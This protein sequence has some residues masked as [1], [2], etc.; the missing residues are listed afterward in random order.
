MTPTALVLSRLPDAKR[1]GRGWVARCPAHDDRRPSLSVAEG[2][3][4]GALLHCHA[5]CAPDAIAA[6]LGLSVRDLMSQSTDAPRDGSSN[7]RA[8]ATFAT[9]RDAVAALEAKHGTRSA[10]WTY[11][12]AD[13]EPVGVIVRFETAR[14]K[15][16]RP[17]ARDGDRWRIGGMPEPRPLY[18]LPDLL[19]T[20]PGDRVFINEGEKATDAMRALGFTATTSPHGAKSAGKADWSP[21]ADR[22]VVILPDADDAGESYAAD[23]AR[24]ATAA[25]ARSVRVVRLRERWPDLPDGGDVADLLE[26]AGGETEALAE[27][28]G[29]IVALVEGAEPERA[30]ADEAPTRDAPEPFA[31]F[32]VE[33]LPEPA[34]SF[35]VESAQAIGCD[36]SY[37]AIPLLAALGSAIGNTHRIELK[38]GWS[39]PPVIFAAILGESG[40]HKTP[41]FRAAL[42]PLRALQTKAFR[43]YERA[44]K[45]WAAEHERYKAQKAAWKRHATKKGADFDEPPE[46]PNPPAARRYIV[47]DTT[48][49][50]LAPIL[51]ANPRGVLLARDELAGWLGSFDR[52]AKSGKAGADAS[53]WLSMHAAESLTIDRKTTIPPTIN[54]PAAAVCIVGGIQP[55][56]LA[57]AMGSEHRES[58]LLARMLFAMPPR[59]VKRWR[60]ACVSPKVERALAAVF[61][62]LVAL[63]SDSDGDGDL[64]PWLVPLSREAKATWI[65]FYNEHARE[66]ADLFGDE[67][68]AWSKLEGYAARLA[69]VVHLTRW[70]AGDTTCDPVAIDAASMTAGITLSRWFGR[71][72]LR[73]YAALSESDADRETRRLVSWIE[74]RGG[75]VTP[76]E[77]AKGVRAY[78]GD[79]E[80]AERAL[81][82]LVDA[83][84][85]AWESVGSTPRGGRP[86]RRFSLSRGQGVPG[87][88]EVYLESMGYG[89]SDAP[90]ESASTES[91]DGDGDAGDGEDWAEV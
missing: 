6:A 45:A 20:E 86:T 66:Q 58:G 63:E 30:A 61:D 10:T 73:V 48:T 26:R 59:R 91:A 76:S 88:S 68:A 18:A 22:N 11:Y 29:G 82:V 21:L 1:N 28:R 69:L 80:A 81:A 72:A 43:E 53:H 67:A 33:A 52:Y 71:E 65:A 54:V 62:K 85:G 27:L 78:R 32:P 5:G 46:A 83:G 16:I 37:V 38:A 7:G 39:E 41:A 77:L 36:I 40:T 34:R 51:L 42:K 44:A 90:S 35:V 4:G 56:I 24:L 14:G 9:A 49:E 55:R 2:D 57:R 31:P 47:S 23:V 8:S 13:G 60:E 17:V 89:D 12:D 3:A 50:A 84:W 79:S 19:A 15:E 70:A 75:A 87:T 64:R 74:H 25:G